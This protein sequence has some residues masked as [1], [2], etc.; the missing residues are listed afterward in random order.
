MNQTETEK[1]DVRADEKSASHKRGPKPKDFGNDR[2]TNDWLNAQ[3]N[4]TRRTYATHWRRFLEYTQM[5][6][7]Q[8]F[9]SRKADKERLW[10]KKVLA[11][12]PW[13]VN[14]KKKSELTA[15]QGTITA[16]SFFDWHDLTLDL[17]RKEKQKLKE[18]QRKTEDYRFSR[19]DLKKMAD[20]G[21]LT[22]RYVTVVG[23]SFGLRAGDF[24]RLTRG[25]LE[26]Y[27][28]REV[29]ISIGEYSTEKESA[30]AF[31]FVDSDAQPI[32]KLML[33]QM[34]REGRTAPTERMLQYKDEIQLSRILQRVADKAGINYGSKNVRFHCLRKFLT[35]H[36]SDYMSESKWK[37]IV[38]KKIS[39]GAYVSADALRQDYAR[40]MAETTFT[41]LVKA[42]DVKLQAKIEAL[43]AIAKGKGVSESTINEILAMVDAKELVSR[44]EKLAYEQSNQNNCS[45]GKNCQQIVS[46]DE[47]AEYLSKGWKTHLVLPSGRIVVDNEH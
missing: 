16:R 41:E 38:G 40:A 29:P 12:K 20:V 33:E 9:E 19:E 13:V 7:D 8:I 43:V 35:D 4:S 42:G 30:K 46:E 14:V 18:A 11:F 31:P 15:R 22:E 21:D 5:T 34:T 36:L 17:R 44:L 37:Q 10:E 26:S 47:L 6:G 1:Q 25:D 27:I 24:L 39:E 2:A 32:V 3:E 28:D 23:K 45:N